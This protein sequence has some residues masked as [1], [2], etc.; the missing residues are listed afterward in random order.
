MNLRKDHYRFGSQC[1]P[2]V[3]SVGWVVGFTRS[4]VHPQSSGKRWFSPLF[5]STP[6]ESSKEVPRGL[7]PSCFGFFY[8]CNPF[9]SFVCVPHLKMHNFQRWIPRLAR[10]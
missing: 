8:F 7:L 1:V 10:R 4:S 9:Y 5:L 3:G 6:F 2:S